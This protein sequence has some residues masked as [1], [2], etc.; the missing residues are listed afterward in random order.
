MSGANTPARD[1]RAPS[2]G[3]ATLW[4]AAKELRAAFRDRQ[5][6][7]YTIV[8]PI[9]LYPFLFWCLIQASLFVQG[10][11]EHTEVQVGLAAAGDARIP[12]GLSDALA[13]RPTSRDD[14]AADDALRRRLAAIDRVRVGPVRQPLDAAAA[15]EWAE[16]RSHAATEDEAR[17][18]PDAVVFVPSAASVDDARASADDN[19]RLTVYYDST[20]TASELARR[21]VVERIPPFV[22]GLRAARLPAGTPSEALEPFRLAPPRDVAPQK[23]QGAYL[24]SFVLPML[25][26]VMCVLG[27]F[28][29]AVDVTAGERERNTAET[30]LLLPVPRRAVHQGK[31]LAVCTGAIVATSLNLFALALSAGH[32]LQ[33][34]PRG[35]DVQI[36]VPL[37]AFAS[38][39]PLALLFAFFVSAALVGI[40]SF[41]RT[42][43]EGQALLG[44]VQMVFILPAMAGAIPNLELTPGL[45]C[46]PVVNVVLAFRALLNGESLPLE[47]AI[48]AAS[49]AASALFA[50]WAS[51]KLLS[52]E[53]LFAPERSGSG[54]VGAWF[55]G[56]FGGGR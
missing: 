34:L 10:R 33:M 48:T 2:V 46:V 5:T 13:L 47:Y 36:E 52:R 28:F 24:L 27:A 12:D 25:L 54:G 26:V 18:L 14:P 9:A 37:A 38:I 50:I 55:S 22:D 11:R 23:D 31:I 16:A 15:R 17:D 21:R 40:A 43:K 7:L 32:L 29:P 3:R 19:A 44:P 6:T 30:T 45:A 53:S 49:L 4:V 20:Q 56:L 41:A 51:V 1:S 35:G 8:L 39:A 42:F